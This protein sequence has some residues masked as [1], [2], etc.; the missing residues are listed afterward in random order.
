M[1][2]SKLISNIKSNKAYK[3]QI[4]HIADIPGQKPSY[5][6]V[7]MD[8][9]ISFALDEMGIE[10]LYTHQ[11]EALRKARS[12]ENYVLSTSTASGKTLCYMVPIFERIKKDPNATAIYISPLNALVNDQLKTFKKFNDIMGLDI[13]INRYTGA[14]SPDER[15]NI[16]YGNPQIIFTNPEMLHLS[17]LQWHNQWKRFLSDLTFIVLDESHTYRGVLGSQMASILRRLNRICEYYGANPQYI[18]CTATI[19]NPVEHTKVL[20]GKKTS[21]IDND[22]SGQG[23]RKF[24]FWNPPYLDEQCNI[25]KGSFADSVRLFTTFVQKDL[26][27]IMFAR[28]RQ[29][30]ERMY[31]QAHRNIS[32][33]LTSKTISSYRGG[34]HNDEREMI[35]KGLSSGNIQG[36]ISTNALELGID[37]GGLDACI[38]DGFPGTIMSTRQQS[39][40][41]GR[42]MHESI[43]VLVA[44]N[45]PLDQYYMNNPQELFR[46]KAEKAV[47]NVANQYILK[48]HILCAAKEMDLKPSDATFFGTD[49]DK[50]VNILEETGCLEKGK[51][52]FSNPHMNLSLRNI[53]SETYT[54]I[55]KGSKKPLENALERSRA[56]M[57][58]HEGA[59]YMNKGRAYI[60]TEQD[61][62]K[63]EVLVEKGF[64]GYYTRSLLSSVIS[65]TTT[66]E[67]D[68]L[69][70]CQEVRSGFGDMKVIQQ[71]TGYKKIQLR[72][73]KVLG[74]FSLNIPP[75]TLD[76]EGFYLELPPDFK[77]IVY[78]NQCDFEGGIHAIVHAIIAMYP[79]HLLADRND[80]EGTYSCEDNRIYLYETRAG[81]VGYAEG[82]FLNIS[83]LLETALGSISTCPCSGGCPSC[84][85][86]STC[87]LH[88]TPLDKEAAIILLHLMLG[89]PAY[90]PKKTHKRTPVKEKED[91]KRP[92]PKQKINMRKLKS[93][94]DWVKDGIDAGKRQKHKKACECFKKALNLE[95]EN[96]NAIMNMGIASMQMNHYHKGLQYFDTMIALGYRGKA[97]MMQKGIALHK[98]GDQQGAI[99]AFDAVLKDDPGDVQVQ[100]FRQMAEK[101]IR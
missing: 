60:V 66:L 99:R 19:G 70:A 73:E 69:P 12:A 58:A 25:R 15:K 89:K 55:E 44:N 80:I 101:K 95:P 20:T 31:A 27:T 62:E 28:S 98:L 1:N 5:S 36:V 72:D 10:Q 16:R 78:D 91:T 85:Q 3:E 50:I 8:P 39:G 97:V 83:D 81:G 30:V 29:R 6:P 45:N 7:D 46:V 86:S 51:P 34:Y 87:G 56:Y 71:V 4:V 17:F 53:Q 42:G 22:S 93:A 11:A 54:I 18:C 52:A 92:G 59:I 26:Q 40:R 77:E 32:D 23:P 47:I 75:F 38:L 13:N 90:I 74:E 65:I 14:M 68:T 63:K 37:I 79:L 94:S 48:D 43:V 82:G 33:S 35:E 2:L 9:L 84:I 21:L 100:K 61:H 88:N 96:P 76:T 64:G 57:E 49:L 67:T 24:V 41:A